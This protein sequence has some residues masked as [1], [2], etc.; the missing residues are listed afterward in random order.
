MP[1]RAIIKGPLRVRLAAW[2]AIVVILTA[3][4]TLL[5]VRQGVQWALIQEIDDFLHEDLREIELALRETPAED[6]DLI[7][8]D[9]ARRAIGH[10]RHGWFV[11]LRGEGDVTRWASDARHR[12]VQFPTG[13]DQ[14]YVT[15][16]NDERVVQQ[17]VAANDHG[18]ESIVV[19]E[20]LQLLRKEISKIDMLV[21]A[22]AACALVAAPIC[23][24]WLAERAARA[25]GEIIRAASRLRPDHLNERLPVLGAGDELDLLASTVNGLLDRMAT[26][27]DRRREVLA[28]AAHELRTPLAA[29]RSSVEVALNED[30]SLE[31]Y[32]ELLEDVID[33]CSSLE[34][35]LNQLLLLAEMETERLKTQK[36]RVA[37]H[38]LVERSVA[39]FQG[40]AECEGRLLVADRLD[41]A[42]VAGNRARLSQ[43]VNNLID[44]AIKYTRHGGRVEVSVQ[45][46]RE[47][48]TAKL[49]VRDDGVGISTADLPHVFERFFRSDRSRT[50]GDYPTGAGL[51]LSICKAVVEAHGGTIEIKSQL[52]RGTECSVTLS[53]E[54]EP[55]AE[56]AATSNDG[57]FAN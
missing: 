14:R 8:Q 9:L 13:D 10:R 20:Q 3:L 1:H 57:I 6:F 47:R 18:V 17:T 42:W 46:D 41:E 24:Y 56:A 49:I 15:L 34:T 37:L 36:E 52:D 28:N 29:I 51:G 35:L 54:R 53:L 33:Q 25:I 7:T 5:V 48:G 39:M 30:R 21:L 31:E 16:I 50:R 55:P 4:I 23:G 12:D 32:Q 44:N 38:E 43:V 27:L 2:N 11:Q 19:G 45:A 26:V 40:V 22:T